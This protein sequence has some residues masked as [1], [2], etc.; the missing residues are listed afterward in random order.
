VRNARGMTLIELL[1]ALA[2]SLILVSTAAFVFIESQKIMNRVDTRLRAAQSFRVTA[3][4]LDSDGA[5]LEPTAYWTTANPPALALRQLGAGGAW[6]TIT[7]VDGATPDAR[8][9]VVKLVTHASVVLLDASK[10]PLPPSDQ[11][12]LITYQIKPGRGLVRTLDVLTLSTN[13]GTGAI[14]ATI[15]D[16]ALPNNN[17]AATPTGLD[18]DLAPGATGFAVRYDMGGVW[19]VP[20]AAGGPGH[21][22]TGAAFTQRLP[23]GLEFTVFIPESPNLPETTRLTLQR[24]VELLPPPP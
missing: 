20:D 14:T 1:I 11:T 7:R 9:D 3:T 6:F 12:V 4:V 5:R 23:S 18:M 21:S 17:G 2:L 24:T 22:D 16:S 8:Q 19:T 15:D 10:N 13:V